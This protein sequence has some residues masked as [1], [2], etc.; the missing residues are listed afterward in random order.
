MT[1]HVMQLKVALG[2]EEKHTA[3]ALVQRAQASVEVPGNGDRVVAFG[4]NI[5]NGKARLN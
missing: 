2:R 4:N 3:L 1:R 5:N